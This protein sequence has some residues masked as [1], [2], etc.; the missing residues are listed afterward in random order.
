MG[1]S[2][3]RAVTA[4]LAAIATSAT[5]AAC[6]SQSSTAGTAAAGTTP[7]PGQSCHAQYE[8]WKNGP[9]RKAALGL[10]AQV[11][12][13]KAAANAEDFVRLDAALKR[14]GRAANTALAYPMPKCADPHG[15]W[16]AF[17][18]RIRS[19]ADNA[20]TGTGLGALLLAIG[21]LKEVPGLL[22]KLDAELKRTVQ[23]KTPL[24]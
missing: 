13:I 21:P 12:G 17:L 8:A 6:G 11:R 19:A 4:V 14:A 10:V 22:N 3:L 2:A 1:V 24:G 7:A 20:S 9:A 15:Y 18:T 16:E 23:G 5:L